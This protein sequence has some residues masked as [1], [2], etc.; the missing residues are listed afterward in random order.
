MWWPVIETQPLTWWRLWMLGTFKATE[1]KLTLYKM[2]YSS[3]PA[4][5]VVELCAGM[6][7]S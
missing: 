5:V 3:H 4:M 6:I 2:W 1:M 7:V